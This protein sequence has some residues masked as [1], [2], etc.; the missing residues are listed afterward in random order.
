MFANSEHMFANS[1]HMFANSKH[2]FA[3]WEHNFLLGKKTKEKQIIFLHFAR[4]S[5]S[6]QEILE[7]L[8]HLWTTNS[9][10]ATVRT[11]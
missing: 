10:K 1:E 7:L 5:L 8:H 4:F 11:S 2:M 9:R 6:L 3:I